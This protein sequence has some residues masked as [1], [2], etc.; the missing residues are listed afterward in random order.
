MDEV[1]DVAVVG[2]GPA[3]SA[4]ALQVLRLR[5]DASV[6]LLDAAEFPR[7]KTCGDGIAAQVFDLL[8]GLGVPGVA[9]LGPLAPRLR[10]RT[11]SGRAV[12][13][14]CPR[15]NRVIT[16]MVF[17]AALVDAA[18]ARGA[19]LRRHRV[20]AVE[21]RGELVHLDREFAARAVIGADGANSTVRRLLGGPVS[22]P[23]AT[24]VALRGYAPTS[25]DTD[26]L[27][28][29]YAQ[30][31]YPAYAWSF[32]IA[33]GGANV[34]Y[35]VFDRRGGG[36]REALLAR[37]RELLPGQEPDPATLRG[38]HLPL[39]TTPRF[40]PDGR[41]LL[42]G[43]AAAKINP[44]TGEG[45]YDA[46][47]SGILAGRDALLGA[48]AG[49]AHRESMRRAFGR[50]HRHVGTISRLAAR[51]RFLDAAISAASRHG[52]VFDAAVELGLAR[53]TVPP[54]A[55]G[56]VLAHLATGR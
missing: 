23:G 24:A 37:L 53:G 19:Q 49:A 56:L 1:Y 2:A 41:V 43:D 55:L 3:G 18:V 32:P 13:R 9:D 16:R 14:A 31:P 30:G 33:G 39:S 35:G 40:H 7:D 51:P 17:D 50:H 48:A 34:G 44:L 12:D 5:P 21:S 45:I 10:L 8:D 47:A 46:I 52:R 54:A 20:R 28:I 26:T 4:A 22:P 11:P 36:N 6:L 29:E 15:P 42:V 25:P 38:H 27:T